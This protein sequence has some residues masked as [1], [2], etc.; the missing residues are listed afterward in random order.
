V[1]VAN[2]FVACL[3]SQDDNHQFP[4]TKRNRHPT[5]SDEASEEGEMHHVREMDISSGDDSVTAA[6]D[7]QFR[8]AA[9]TLP[10]LL[11]LFRE[12]LHAGIAAV[13]VLPLT[14]GHVQ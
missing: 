14:Q 6:G 13:F 8:R 5:N 12:L 3:L 2:A 4:G 1:I 11:E 10:C 9:Q 7:L